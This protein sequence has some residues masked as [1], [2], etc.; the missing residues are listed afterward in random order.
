MT[1]VLASR[2]SIR[3]CACRRVGIGRS[4]EDVRALAG[5]HKTA[6]RRPHL[7]AA[8]DSAGIGSGKRPEPVLRHRD[9]GRCDFQ[10]IRRLPEAV[11][12]AALDLWK[13][14]SRVTSAFPFPRAVPMR[15]SCT[16][17]IA[18]LLFVTDSTHSHGTVLP[19]ER[20]L[21]G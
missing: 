19:N 12:G 13:T 14:G 21:V 3:S 8:R 1:G 5:N 9:G 6:Q 18:R 16:A 20:K 2:P 11:H 4:D 17:G 7:N 15:P 10:T